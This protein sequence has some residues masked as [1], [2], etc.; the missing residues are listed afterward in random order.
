MTDRSMLR[1]MVAAL[2]Y[3]AS[4]AMRNAPDSFADFRASPTSRTP[5]EI[6]AH[7]G[8]LFDW[9]LTMAQGRTA[10]NNAT[11]QAWPNEVAR[12]FET[13]TTFDQFLATDAPIDE[14]TLEQLAQGPVADALTHTG[15][16]TLLRRA[17]GAPV[18]G[19]SYARA[20]IAIGST[21]FEQPAPRVEFD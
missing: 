1:H 9:A 15:Q 10:W 21:S 14:R 4:K 6:V 20:D 18:R 19:E 17:A 11:P 5:V 2:A 3:R 12:F 8:D 7:M 13:L 16:L